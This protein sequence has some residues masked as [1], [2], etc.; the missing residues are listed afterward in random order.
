[1]SFPQEYLFMWC[2]SLTCS[3]I[4]LFAK[5]T[6][7]LLNL[8]HILPVRFP[9]ITSFTFRFS[10]SF[11]STQ[12]LTSW[13]RNS[14]VSM[15]TGYKLDDL[16]VEVPVTVGSKLCEQYLGPTDFPIQ[17]VPGSFSAGVKRSGRETDHSR[18]TSVQVKKP[19]I[20]KS[21]PP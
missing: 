18:A 8:C 5:S 17:L 11:P 13:S 21:I 3:V 15:A 19:W 16:W 10:I 12:L 7:L 9:F 6:L 2:L 20:Y 4:F 1:M 14:A